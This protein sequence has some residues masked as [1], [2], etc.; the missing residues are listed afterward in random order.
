MIRTALA[1]LFAVL[2]LG[3]GLV[4]VSSAITFGDR[5]VEVYEPPPPPPYPQRVIQEWGDICSTNDDCRDREPCM[6]GVCT[7]IDPPARCF[8]TFT[9]DT[10][11]DNGNDCT[12]NDVCYLDH[13]PDSQQCADLGGT[14]VFADVPTECIYCKTGTPKNCRDDDS[15]TNDSCEMGICLNTPD[16]SN[17]ANCCVSDEDCPDISVCKDRSCSLDENVCKEVDVTSCI[18]DDGCCP[19]DDDGLPLC[20]HNYDNDCDPDCGNGVLEEGEDCDPG[21]APGSAGACP[22]DMNCSDGQVCTSDEIIIN[23]C[24][25]YCHNPQITACVDDDGCCPTGCNSV[26]DNDCPTTCGNGV[27]EEGEDC[28][29]EIPAGSEGACPTTC[30]DGKACTHDVPVG[31]CN[32]SCISTEITRCNDGDG[33]CPADCDSQSDSDCSRSCGDGVHD[34]G[35]IC[36]TGIPEGLPGACKTADQ[37]DDGIACTE[38]RLIGAACSADCSNTS[39]NECRNGDG[40]CPA[41][42]KSESDSDCSSSCGDDVVDPG[43]TCDPCPTSCD[44]GNDKTKDTLT[45]SAENCNVACTNTP[46]TEPVTESPVPPAVECPKGFITVAGAEVFEGKDGPENLMFGELQII[47]NLEQV[48]T[49]GG[50]ALSLPLKATLVQLEGSVPRVTIAKEVAIVIPDLPVATLKNA[51][52][53]VNKWEIGGVHGVGVSGKQKQLIAQGPVA[54]TSNPMVFT[55]QHAALFANLPK[56]GRQ[57][58]AY[59]LALNTSAGTVGTCPVLYIQQAGVIGGQCALTVP[60]ST[61][62]QGPWMAFLILLLPVSLLWLFRRAYQLK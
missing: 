7:Q 38:D 47:V 30:N 32:P 60:G 57:P 19:T 25:A 27:V 1:T 5:P 50:K 16:A 41:G 10:P 20:N 14:T 31:E 22:P 39:V 53:E 26:N 28:D 6:P 29:T 46:I 36:D 49:T 54:D 34:P 35:E 33:C 59:A 17:G 24:K 55:I 51:I 44:D 52:V 45:G 12:V 11:C 8:Y 43:E 21:I 23:D 42:C 56:N 9:P 3:V 2:C 15:C 58:Q 48:T 62:V 13:I 18:H 4:S 61:T 40:C 37:C